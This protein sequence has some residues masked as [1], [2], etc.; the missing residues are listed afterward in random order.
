MTAVAFLGL[1]RMGLP[2]AANLVAAGHDVTVWNRTPEKA[3][4]FAAEHGAHAAATPAEAAARADV[5]ITMLADDR[6]LLDV[7]TGAGGALTTVRPG[8]LAIDMATVSPGTIAHARPAAER[9]RGR[10]RR[11]AGVGQ[12]SG[13]DGR[14]PD[15]H[16]GGGARSGRTRPGGPRRRSV[17]ASW[18]SDPAAPAPR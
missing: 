11:R 6:A 18:C 9:A 14:H 5:V 16:G 12:C 7:W 8:T 2:M 10:P 17:T 3:Q 13:R 1:G 4:Q 15:D